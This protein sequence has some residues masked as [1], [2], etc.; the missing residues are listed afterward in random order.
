LEEAEIIKPILL[1]ELQNET[2]QL[3]AIFTTIS[4]KSKAK[5]NG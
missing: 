5:Q 2:D 4:K 1:E 3:I